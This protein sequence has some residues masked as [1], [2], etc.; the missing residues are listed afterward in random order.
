VIT[1]RCKLLAAAAPLLLV[2]A[3]TAETVEDG[4]ACDE[5]E[6]VICTYLGKGEAGLGHD[7]VGCRST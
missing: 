5:A 1:M 6:G 4:P 3:C 7:G 2:S